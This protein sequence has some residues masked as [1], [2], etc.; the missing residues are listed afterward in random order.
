MLLHTPNLSHQYLWPILT[1]LHSYWSPCTHS[2]AP[3][4]NA[5]DEP[6]RVTVVKQKCERVT[7][8]LKKKIPVASHHIQTKTQTPYYGLQG[9]TWPKP[10]PALWSVG[11]RSPYS[12]LSCH[13]SLV[14]IGELPSSW[15]L[16]QSLYTCVLCLECTPQPPLPCMARPLRSYEF[17][18]KCCLLLLPWPPS[19]LAVPVPL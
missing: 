15:L 4:V 3:T 8:L 18:S 16:P 14:T 11:A 9:L 2:R 7:L 13:T 10:R 17:L 12:L 19:K 5:H 6:G 1:A